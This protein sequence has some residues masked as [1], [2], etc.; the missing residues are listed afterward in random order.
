MRLLNTIPIFDE[1]TNKLW[2]INKH[3]WRTNNRQYW[4]INTCYAAHNSHQS[5]KSNFV[6]CH[7]AHAYVTIS[8]FVIKK[9]NC[10]LSASDVLRLN[11][12]THRYTQIITVKV[13]PSEF[14]MRDKP[15][16]EKKQKTKTK[17]IKIWNIQQQQQKK[18]KFLFR[19]HAVLLQTEHFEESI[20]YIELVRVSDRISNVCDVCVFVWLFNINRFSLTALHYSILS[21]R[22]SKWT[23]YIPHAVAI[24]APREYKTYTIV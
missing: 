9:I 7:M 10:T 19:T 18:A 17:V 15:N 1:R 4:L 5:R 13:R 8:N 20:Q 22:Q 16:T 11:L 14:C 3:A 23:V 6:H 12:T 2:S 21:T 24:I